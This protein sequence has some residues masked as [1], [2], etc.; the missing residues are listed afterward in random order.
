M[1]RPPDPRVARASPY[2]DMLR[3]RYEAGAQIGDLAYWYSTSRFYMAFMLQLAG[4]KFRH[5]VSKRRTR[6]E[7]P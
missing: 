6:T 1:R 2:M 3:F 7:A 4:T 5:R